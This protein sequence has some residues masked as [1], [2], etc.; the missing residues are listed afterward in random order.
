MKEISLQ[1]IQSKATWCLA[2]FSLHCKWQRD[3]QRR[4]RLQPRDP[5]P[6]RLLTTSQTVPVSLFFVWMTSV[7]S[8]KY[9]YWKW[10]ES[11]V[12]WLPATTAGQRTATQLRFR[13]NPCLCFGQCIIICN[14][15]K[16]QNKN[17]PEK[18]GFYPAW[19]QNLKILR[20]LLKATCT[21]MNTHENKQLYVYTVYIHNA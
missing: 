3:Y 6:A 12:V 7:I 5:L 8:S 18:W 20:R 9:T 10:E 2:F 15:L 4:L 21:D 19:A 11:T 17:M 13:L 16:C 14:M 1:I